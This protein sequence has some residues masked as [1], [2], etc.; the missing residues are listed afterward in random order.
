MRLR[1]QLGA[2]LS[3]G[4]EYMGWIIAIVIVVLI[5]SLGIGAFFWL[6]AHAEDWS[7]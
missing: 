1:A 4:G 2:S 7:E 5:L 6:V 3:L